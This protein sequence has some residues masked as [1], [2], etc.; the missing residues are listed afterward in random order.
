MQL[1]KEDASAVWR[2]HFIEMEFLR[3]RLD[4]MVVSFGPEGLCSVPPRG[5]MSG[6][7]SN[8]MAGI[9]VMAR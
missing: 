8:G 2:N 1:L 9:R 4:N 7:E 5:R 6:I 3:F